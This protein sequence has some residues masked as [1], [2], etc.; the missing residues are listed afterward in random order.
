M[1]RHGSSRPW[2]GTRVAMRIICSTSALSGAGCL[3]SGIGGEIRLARKSTI[4]LVM[5]WQFLGFAGLKRTRRRDGTLWLRGDS[6]EIATSLGFMAS[7][8]RGLQ[9]VDGGIR[10]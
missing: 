1:N 8:E 3:S 10:H 2:S 9:T 5:G 7:N 6:L 4:A